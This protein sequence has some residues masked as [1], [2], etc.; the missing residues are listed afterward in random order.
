MIQ[1]N[2]TARTSSHSEINRQLAKKVGDYGFGK[3]YTLIRRTYLIQII[4]VHDDA[5]VKALVEYK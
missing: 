2:Q 1:T 4:D 3:K 5:R